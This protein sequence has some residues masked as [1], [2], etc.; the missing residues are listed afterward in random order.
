MVGFFSTSSDKPAK[1]VA[2]EYVVDAAKNLGVPKENIML[3]A[4]NRV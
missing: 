2:Q 1:Q 4:F 3:T